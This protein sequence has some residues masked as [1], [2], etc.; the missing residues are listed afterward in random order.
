MRTL[1]L[2]LMLA[3]A[4]CVDIESVSQPI[5][6]VKPPPKFEFHDRVEFEYGFFGKCSGVVGGP[7]WWTD[8]C[9]RDSTAQYVYFFDKI[10]CDGEELSDHFVNAVCER[11]IKLRKKRKP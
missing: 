7:P 9:G 3:F 10:K 8:Y 11:N 2:V 4:G 5:Q 6:T 1:L